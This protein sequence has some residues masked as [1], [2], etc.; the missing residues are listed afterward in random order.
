[1]YYLLWLSCNWVCYYR[2]TSRQ[3][4]T[5]TWMQWWFSAR[6]SPPRRPLT[7]APSPPQRGSTISS[8][9]CSNTGSP[10]L[11]RRPTRCTAR[12]AARSSSAPGWMQRYRVRRCSRR[13]IRSTGKAAHHP[14]TQT[15][16]ITSVSCFDGQILGPMAKWPSM[17]RSGCEDAEL[18]SKGPCYP[19]LT[20]HWA[21]AQLSHFGHPT[22]MRFWNAH[23]YIYNQY[24][25]F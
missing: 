13:R 6:P 20:G 17:V 1:M 8:L 2:Y 15:K 7:S 10:H 3:W 24:F 4:W 11:L 21:P 12:W 5:L 25:L 14:L 22:I 23:I 9:W 19:L 18:L 16:P